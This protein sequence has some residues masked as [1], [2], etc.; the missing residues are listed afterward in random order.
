[1]IEK[2]LFLYGGSPPFGE[3][4]GKLFADLA[5]SN[6]GKIAILFIPRDGWKEYMNIYTSILR[7][8]GHKNFEY[9]PLTEKAKETNR[10]KLLECTGLIISGGETE[11]YQ[12]MIV[13]T[14]LAKQIRDLYEQGVP[15]AG[16][17]A[18]ALISPEHCIIP[19]IDNTKGKKLILKGLGLVKNTVISVHYSKWQEAENLQANVRKLGV[20]TGY[21]LDDDTAAYFRNEELAD[22]EGNGL[23]TWCRDSHS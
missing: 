19:P 17:S 2:H 14:E 7:K 6:N 5:F 22:T 12:E 3:R 9:L 21:G 8:H 20:S 15:V 18:G 4:F 1:M 10:I 13:S 11:R 23:Y 16:F